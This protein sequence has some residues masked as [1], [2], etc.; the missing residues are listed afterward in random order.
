[1]S[2]LSN[3][4]DED[5]VK[6]ISNLVESKMN[7]L[8]KVPAFKEKDQNL[9]IATEDFENALSDELNDKFDDVMRLHYQID[10]YYFTLAYFLGLQHGEQYKKI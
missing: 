3:L 1:M 10:S 8:N 9:A 7:L 5:T 6:D 2:D 4:F